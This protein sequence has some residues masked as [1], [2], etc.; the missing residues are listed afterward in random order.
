MAYKQHV[1]RS[2]VYYL[3]PDCILLLRRSTVS[4]KDLEYAASIYRK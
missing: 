4:C 1:R 3:S 2:V